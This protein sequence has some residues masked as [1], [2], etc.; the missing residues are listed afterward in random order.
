MSNRFAPSLHCAHEPVLTAERKLWRAVLEQARVDCDLPLFSDGIAPM[1]R[2]LAR[3]L[4]R[5]ASADEADILR[6]VC[7]FAGVPADRLILWARRRYPPERTVEPDVECGSL[8]QAS[9]APAV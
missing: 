7:D 2:I 5:A 4:L 1:E 8:P 3:R 9:L 6:L